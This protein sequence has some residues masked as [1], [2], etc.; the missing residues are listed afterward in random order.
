MITEHRR[1][2]FA[3]DRVLDAIAHCAG[4]SQIALPPGHVVGLRINAD[5]SCCLKIERLG[6]ASRSEIE[7]KPAQMAAILLSYAKH[8]SIPIP[9]R[10][11]KSL[12]GSRDGLALV[13]TLDHAA[14]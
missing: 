13:V 10:G 8:L 14:E 1:I 9:K 3:R 12:E 6:G 4:A 11:A 5:G 2:N 7:C